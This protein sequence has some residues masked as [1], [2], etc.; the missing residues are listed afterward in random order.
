MKYILCITGVTVPG[1]PRD[2]T[3]RPAGSGAA[4]VPCRA[5]RGRHWAAGVQSGTAFCPPS[6]RVGGRGSGKPVGEW[7]RVRRAGGGGSNPSTRRGR[8]P[9]QPGGGDAAWTLEKRDAKKT[10]KNAKINANKCKK[11]HIVCKI[12]S[13]GVPRDM[14]TFCSRGLSALLEKIL[15]FA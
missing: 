9:P 13:L 6:V 12:N 11:T 7:T 10:G 3:S 2:Q 8:I 14:R 4:S 1:R 15:H 5:P